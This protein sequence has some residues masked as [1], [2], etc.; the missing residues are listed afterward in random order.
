MTSHAVSFLYSLSMAQNGADENF[1]LQA[2]PWTNNN[3]VQLG[4]FAIPLRM[5]SWLRYSRLDHGK[6][7][8]FHEKF[9]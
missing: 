8:D 7:D 1:L 9:E 2:L 4:A 3:L 6:R 5:W